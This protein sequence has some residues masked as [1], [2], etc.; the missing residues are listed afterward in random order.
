MNQLHFTLTPPKNW[1]QDC[2]TQSNLFQ[3]QDWQMVLHQGFKTQA[4]YGWNPSNQTKMVI[5]LFKAGPFKIGYLEFP[6]TDIAEFSLNNDNITALKQSIPIPIDI[7]YLPISAF[8][9]AT[10]LDLNYVITSETAITDLPNWQ[11]SQLPK[12]LRR[13]IKK[14]NNS[15]LEVIDASTPDHGNICYQLYQQTI[16]RHNG[17]LR[18]TLD[19][20]QAIMQLSQT[21]PKLRC[22][23]AYLN[24]EIAGFLIVALH[25]QTAYYLHGAINFELKRYGISDKLLYEA[26]LWAQSQQMKHFNFMASPPSQTSLIRYKEKWGGMTKTQK[27]YELNIRPLHSQGFKISKRLYYYFSKY[28]REIL[29]LNADAF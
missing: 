11:L 2:A 10:A 22:L 21:Q 4:I 26:I 18:Y 1:H 23:L 17:N 20:F 7:L 14:A 3:S 29:P 6:V 5:T 9:N 13:D 15:N 19:Y 24:G 25:Y 16:Q 12:K 28:F 27:N 8:T